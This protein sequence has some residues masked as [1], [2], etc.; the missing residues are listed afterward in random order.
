MGASEELKKGFAYQHVLFIPCTYHLICFDV[1][2]LSDRNFGI[3][4]VHGDRPDIRG[5]ICFRGSYSICKFSFICLTCL[6]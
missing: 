1:V 3:F 5:V 6:E 4:E 2:T